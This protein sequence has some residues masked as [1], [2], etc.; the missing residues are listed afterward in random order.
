MQNQKPR[1]LIDFNQILDNICLKNDFQLEFQFIKKTGFNFKPS[2]HTSF[3]IVFII[4]TMVGSC[5]R[6]NTNVSSSK[7]LYCSK[8]LMHKCCAILSLQSVSKIWTTMSPFVSSTGNKF[9]LERSN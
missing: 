8:L 2:S 3:I 4:F 6:A 9:G 7:T 5:M 1:S